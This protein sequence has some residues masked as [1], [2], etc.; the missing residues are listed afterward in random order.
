MADSIT[1]PSHNAQKMFQDDVNSTYTRI[2]SRTAELRAN[3]PS[4]NDPNNDTSTGVEQIQLHATDPDS[5]IFI[6]IPQPS[7]KD[8]IE[9]EARKTF[10][11]FPPG[12]Q[13]AM[14]SGKLERINEVLGKMSV[15]EA[16]EVVG[17][18][19]EGGMLSMEKGVID[20]TT[21]EGRQRLK[22]MEEERKG[23]KGEEDGEGGR[24]GDKEGMKGRDGL[25]EELRRMAEEGEG[26][27][28]DV[29]V[30]DVD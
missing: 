10:E 23:R 17:K 7:S 9:I 8:T 25:E 20:G 5:Q 24:G 27:E 18:M 26:K 22:D 12:L 29:E 3:P 1:T 30:A 14:E 28:K 2:A 4:S 21:E 15:E 19:G 6:N 11:T 13:R 16:E